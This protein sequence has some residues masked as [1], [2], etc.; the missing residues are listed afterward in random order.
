MLNT[1]VY[2]MLIMLWGKLRF[3][4]F[5]IEQNWHVAC[6]FCCTFVTMCGLRLRSP[7]AND[8][9]YY[10][11]HIWVCSDDVAKRAFPD[12][13]INSTFLG[14]CI[15]MVT[16]PIARMKEHGGSFRISI[17]RARRAVALWLRVVKQFFCT[18]KGPRRI[19]WTVRSHE[20]QIIFPNLLRL[21]LP[22]CCVHWS[23]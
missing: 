11:T 21:K 4:P 9:H 14:C 16:S 12:F 13:A 5:F 23:D 3:L 19:V 10:P 22:F 15:S 2:K 6:R 17:A 18:L 20:E 8:G 1:F 7:S